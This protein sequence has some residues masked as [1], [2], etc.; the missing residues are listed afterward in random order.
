MHWRQSNQLSEM[1]HAIKWVLDQKLQQ[2]CVDFRERMRRI[3]AEVGRKAVE[4]FLK[5]ESLAYYELLL[6]VRDKSGDFHHDELRTKLIDHF[7]N[8]PN[9]E[10]GHRDYFV[11]QSLNVKNDPDNIREIVKNFPEEANAYIAKVKFDRYSQYMKILHSDEINSPKF[12]KD[13]IAQ[14]TEDIGIKRSPAKRYKKILFLAENNLALFKKCYQ[15]M[16]LSK[17]QKEV[18]DLIVRVSI[19]SPQIRELAYSKYD[20]D[21]VA[22]FLGKLAYADSEAFNFCHFNAETLGLDP[23]LMDLVKI[24]DSDQYYDQKRVFKLVLAASYS[25]NYNSNDATKKWEKVVDRLYNENPELTK[26]CIAELPKKVKNVYDPILKSIEKQRSIK[27]SSD[28]RGI[29]G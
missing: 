28:N 2:R 6:W 9:I 8:N 1:T 24:P 7:K 19:I 25:I 17:D 5:N 18:C 12:I 4:D 23:K 13:A 11:K 14:A 15:E 10:D 22:A 26:E 20:Q 16:D 3:E 27:D 29:G 21:K